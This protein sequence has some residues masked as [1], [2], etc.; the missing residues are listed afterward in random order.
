MKFNF[1]STASKKHFDKEEKKI[2]F[3]F[4][5]IILQKLDFEEKDG[6][7]TIKPKQR[8]QFELSDSVFALLGNPTKVTLGQLNDD[9]CILNADS[10][11]EEFIKEFKVTVLPLS[12]ENKFTHEK[13]YSYIIDKCKLSHFKDNHFVAYELENYKGVLIV[14]Y[15]ENPSAE[16]NDEVLNQLETNN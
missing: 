3:P 9:I 16:T 13:K 11:T 6:V 1:E 4:P 12:K 8:R 5:Y 15:V 2:K 7:K 14:P 10:Y